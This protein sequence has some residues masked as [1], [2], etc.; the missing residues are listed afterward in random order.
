VATNAE[1]TQAT[2]EVMVVAGDLAVVVLADIVGLAAMV[3]NPAKL[4]T[5]LVVMDPVEEEVE[6]AVHGLMVGILEVV[7]VAV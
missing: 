3:G 6:V 5:G 7:A 4:L 1:D 2:A